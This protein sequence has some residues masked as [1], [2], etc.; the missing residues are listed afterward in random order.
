VAV[1]EFVLNVTLIL[2]FLLYGNK[3]FSRTELEN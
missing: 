1:V 3:E 2:S